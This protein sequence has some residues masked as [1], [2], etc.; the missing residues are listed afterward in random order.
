MDPL[1]GRRQKVGLGV[2]VALSANRGF[3]RSARQRGAQGPVQV[4]EPEG[5]GPARPGSARKLFSECDLLVTPSFLPKTP[6]S[7][8]NKLLATSFIRQAL[9][10]PI[11]PK[12]LR[13]D[14]GVWGTGEL[15]VCGARA[16]LGSF[17]VAGSFPAR[18][19]EV[20]YFNC[21]LQA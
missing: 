6:I 1:G 4:S 11:S 18:R 12:I 2:T 10:F 5:T 20:N 19:D 14:L 21:N 7:L 9:G 17:T 8:P 15:D 16:S 3:E 13:K